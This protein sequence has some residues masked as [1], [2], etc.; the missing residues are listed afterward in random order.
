M[1]KILNKIKARKER[2]GYPNWTEFILTFGVA[3]EEDGGFLLTIY[4]WGGAAAMFAMWVMLK[5]GNNT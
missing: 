3:R 4:G 5:F 1:K 2:M